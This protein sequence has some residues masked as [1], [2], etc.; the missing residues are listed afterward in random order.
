MSATASITTAEMIQQLRE[1][2]D[3]LESGKAGVQGYTYVT[4]ELP[5]QVSKRSIDIDYVL[6]EMK[7]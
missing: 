7:G 1:V 4:Q 3:L 2:A 6:K 5:Y